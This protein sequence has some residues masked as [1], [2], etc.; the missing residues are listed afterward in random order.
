MTAH[1]AVFASIVA[2]GDLVTVHTDT[3][4]SKRVAIGSGSMLGQQRSALVYPS[5]RQ[6]EM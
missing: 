2:E 1:P 5:E 6:V 4:V 3:D